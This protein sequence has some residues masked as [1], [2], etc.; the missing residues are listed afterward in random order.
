MVEYNFPPTGKVLAPLTGVVVSVY[1]VQDEAEVT[2]VA[3]LVIA[4]T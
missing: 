3:P 1:A 4:R 2:C